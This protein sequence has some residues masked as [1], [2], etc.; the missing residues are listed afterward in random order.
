MVRLCATRGGRAQD[1]TWSASD[2][3]TLGT[4]E[5]WTWGTVDGTPLGD[6]TDWA[7]TDCKLSQGL[8]QAVMKHS[9]TDLL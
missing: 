5:E 1:W 9:P 3:T 6:L 7:L 4:L 2:G 8:R